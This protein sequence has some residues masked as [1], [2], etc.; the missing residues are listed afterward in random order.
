MALVTP[1]RPSMSVPAM[2]PD[3]RRRSPRLRP[4]ILSAPHP[5][6]N[7][8]SQPVSLSLHPGPKSGIADIPSFPFRKELRHK[9]AVLEFLDGQLTGLE[10]SAGGAELPFEFRRGFVGYLEYELKELCEDGLGQ[11]NRHAWEL[12]ENGLGQHNR[13]GRNYRNF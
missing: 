3:K 5:H 7:V 9:C 13:H 6:P 1:I 12:C 2:A 4:A 11:H 8:T 10:L